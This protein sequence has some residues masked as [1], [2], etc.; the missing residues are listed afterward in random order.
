[1]NCP[2]FPKDCEMLEELGKF[3]T[4][5]FVNVTYALKMT[6]CKTDEHKSCEVYKLKSE[7]DNQVP[8]K[9]DIGICGIPK[10]FFEQ[11]I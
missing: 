5:N 2:Y 4:T 8:A 11:A 10:E 3:D 7:M 9:H 6:A 1:M